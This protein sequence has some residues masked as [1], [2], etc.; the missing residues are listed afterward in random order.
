LG[1]IRRAFKVYGGK[2]HMNEE[3]KQ[4]IEDAQNEIPNNL[5]WVEED[6]GLWKGWTYSPEK[7]RYYF[8]DIGSESLT[9]F[10]SDEFLNQA[11][12]RV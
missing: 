10:W 9:E 2:W 3:L 7:N 5:T 6:L 1:K 8:N 11:Y 4:A 12:E